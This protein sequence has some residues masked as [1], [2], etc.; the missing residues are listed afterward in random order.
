M[1]TIHLDNDITIMYIQAVSFPEGLPKAYEKLHALLPFGE[2][3]KFISLSCMD[4]NQSIIYRAGAEAL[5]ENEATEFGLPTLELKK[6]R[7]LSITIRNFMEDTLMI[8]QAFQTLMQDPRIDPEGYCVEWYFNDPDV[9][10]MIR[11]MD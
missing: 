5:H 7:Y 1:E 6:G 10:C 3:R 9:H 2:E 11:L 4:A 8:G